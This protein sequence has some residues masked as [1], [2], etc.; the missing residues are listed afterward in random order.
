MEAPEGFEAVPERPAWDA[1]KKAYRV[2]VRTS[3]ELLPGSHR[4]RVAVVTDVKR[5][6]RRTA[7]VRVEVVG[8]EA[9]ARPR[10]LVFGPAA[11]GASAGTVELSAPEAFEVT[12]VTCPPDRVMAAVRALEPGRRYALDFTVDPQAPSGDRHGRVA[13]DLTDG[14]LSETVSIPVFGTVAIK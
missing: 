11:P 7:P 9:Q 6:A 5:V 14:I 3:P 1:G 10:V 12:R 13:V 8:L 2:T 4:G